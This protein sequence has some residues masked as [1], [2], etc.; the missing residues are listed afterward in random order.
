MLRVDCYDFY[1]LGIQIHPLTLMAD[2]IT[3]ND[4]WISLYLART[5]LN[6]FFVTFSLKTSRNPA[7]ALYEAIGALVPDDFS[8]VRFSD[9]EG[10]PRV[11]DFSELNPIRT[12]AK[13]FE[14][15]LKAEL[16]GW[17]AF[18]VS[19]KGAY[20]T[21]D[22]INQ[23]ETMLP[24]EA[25][26]T[27]LSAESKEDIR[28]AG[29][30]L[31]FN[32]GTAAAFHMVRATETFI[33][34]YYEAV[35]GTLPPVKVRNWGTYSRNLAK[36]GKADTRVVGWLDHI[37]LEYRNPVLHPQEFVT[38]DGALEFINACIALIMSI[39]RALEKL[40]EDRR[41]EDEVN[42]AIAALAGSGNKFIEGVRSNDAESAIGLEA[43][44][45]ETT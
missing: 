24:S 44:A 30:C 42:A 3:L 16:N 12:A 5:E 23:A 13:E 28:Q 14:T 26:R 1:K 40:A 27:L 31:A 32:L 22:L 7:S 11:L 21:A 19:Q 45:S 33:W 25:A 43:G 6:S 41:K 8:Q 20:S 10:K 15:V 38:S 2:D 34:K 17:D 9:G 18:F 39:V 36:C 35:I 37:R 29:R 4:A